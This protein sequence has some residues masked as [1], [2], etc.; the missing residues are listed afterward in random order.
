M[1]INSTLY[2]TLK[3]QLGSASVV[4]NASGTIL[5]ENRYYPFGETRLT[6]GTIFTDKLF[7]GQREMAGL[8][9]YHYGARF[10]SPKLGRFLS[11]DTI[12][13]GYA[14][15]QNLN[16]FSY[17]RNNP[18]RYTDPTG[19]YVPCEADAG[20]C[21]HDPAPSPAP[22]GS[23]G[24]GGGGGGDDDDD[25]P[26]PNCMGCS[27]YGDTDE[28]LAA[29]ISFALDY[30]PFGWVCEDVYDHFWEQLTNWLLP[31]Y[32]SGSKN[33]LYAM[34]ALMAGGSQGITI[35]TTPDGQA[36][37]YYEHSELGYTATSGPNVSINI[38]KGTISGMLNPSEY[39]GKAISGSVYGGP[40][41]VGAWTTPG[42]KLGGLDV[43][44][45]L[46]AS[47]PVG[48]TASITY[49]DPIGGGQYKGFN[50]FICR[51]VLAGCGR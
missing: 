9:I 4:T 36:V 31:A 24:G 12:V 13:P 50:F 32:T 35:V 8:G 1:R 34:Y 40:L 2:Y 21:H 41:S 23:G 17:V 19:H 48:A 33:E 39:E 26:N 7:T 28:R 22:G 37:V 20:E 45:S 51:A 5:G 15:P 10:Y 38:T 6:T 43:T 29:A 47:L 42:R 3:D 27:A 14:N 49:A 30:C 44:G 16:R 11:A 18:L 25:D 46:G